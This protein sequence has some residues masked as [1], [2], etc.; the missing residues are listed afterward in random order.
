LEGGKPIWM[1]DM[2]TCSEIG[3][4]NTI[5]FASSCMRSCCRSEQG[6]PA[7]GGRRSLL[8]AG[9]GEGQVS[10]PRLIQ[11]HA[12]HRE[13]PDAVLPQARKQQVTVNY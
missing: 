5:I 4:E 11:I 10:R 1:H 13:N 3:G 7:R 8:E 9:P 6:P 12:W 2:G